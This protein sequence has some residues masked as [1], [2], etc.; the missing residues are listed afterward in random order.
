[1]QD[2]IRG[3]RPVVIAI[4]LSAAWTL[5]RKAC[6]S[7]PAAILGILAAVVGLCKVNPM[8]VLVMA[9]A[10][11]LSIGKR[12]LT[13]E[14]PSCPVAT[15]PLPPEPLPQEKAAKGA[16]VVPCFVIAQ[17]LNTAGGASFLQ[18]GL[19][20]LKFGM[21][22]FGGGFVLIPVLHRTL[23]ENLHWLSS[24][25]FL[26]GIALSNLTPGPVAVLSTFA[27]YKV[28]GLAGA[29]VATVGLFLP[30]FALMCILCRQYEKMK[31][32]AKTQDFLAGIA[33]A[34]IGLI[35]SAAVML[36]REA[37]VS[38]HAW[39]L[40]AISLLLLIRWRLHPVV[41]LAVGA[42]AGATVLR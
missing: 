12:R 29:M 4:I 23:V 33:P 36:S 9:G 31:G 22:F 37:I 10:F 7:W 21:V 35:F 17:G 30:G 26:D 28:L 39:A 14:E 32:G 42:L 3:L 34:V 41:V 2:V 1:M 18:L 16:G 38:W 11:G 40:A 13:G 8:V 19:T 27:G 15:S 20:F 24:Q 5:G 6:R 25:E